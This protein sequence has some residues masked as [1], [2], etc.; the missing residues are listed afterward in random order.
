MRR[1]PFVSPPVCSSLPALFAFVLSFFFSFLSFFLSRVGRFHLLRGG[2][3]LVRV[4]GL[5]WSGALYFG[6]EC[7]FSIVLFYVPHI[8]AQV[9]RLWLVTL[10]YRHSYLIFK[11][12]ECLWNVAVQ[13]HFQGAVTRLDVSPAPRGVVGP[14]HYLS[15]IF[16]NL[17]LRQVSRIE[18]ETAHTRT[19]V[20]PGCRWV[21]S[22]FLPRILTPV[23]SSQLPRRHP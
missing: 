20:P 22:R 14:R 21:S 16:K 4:G 23:N 1:H 8:S 13:S 15:E 12:I 10:T 5:L 17:F 3:R 9:T 2:N 19:E 7:L 11:G 18:G 6:G